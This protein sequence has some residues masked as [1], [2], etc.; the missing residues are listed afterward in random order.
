MAAEKEPLLIAKDVRKR[1]G[2][3][4]VLKGVNMEV[5]E[6]EVVGIIGPSGSGKST[7]L[8]CIDFIEEYDGGEIRLGNE[9]VGYDLTNGRRSRLPESKIVRQRVEIGMV[10]QSFNL[11][12]HF[13]VGQNIMFGLRKVRGKD[14][15]QAEEIAQQWL[16]RVGLSDK[17]KAFPFQLS[18]GQQQRVAIARAV[19]L[20]PRVMLFDEVT[21]ALD[22]EIVGE[23]LK[24][25]GDLASSG[26]TMI[27][28]SHEMLF[29]KEVANRV[30][31]MDE[32]VIVEQGAPTQLLANPE[33][34]RMKAFLKRFQGI[35]LG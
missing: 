14:R 7:F 22:P 29:I 23:V 2:Q 33:S 10:F 28:V 13:T 21:S 12:P 3:L 26:M 30:V 35:F 8:K 18:G 4:E 9:T 17:W 25:M 34:E 31:F 5:D 20:E 11:F 1:F 24:V 6:G 27:V 15:K 32:G 16:G 19:A